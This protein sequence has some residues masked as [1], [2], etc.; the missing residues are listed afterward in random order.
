MK[1]SD[2]E[3]LDV[4][5]A[6]LHGGA[7]APASAAPAATKTRKASKATT[8]DPSA[9]FKV[10]TDPAYPHNAQLVFDKRPTSAVCADLKQ[11]GFQWSPKNRRWYGPVANVP[12][13][14]RIR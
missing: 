2:R 6:M 3:I 10:E 4:L 12:T 1:A 7:A 11:R 9:R 8:G 14:G 13:M 5:R